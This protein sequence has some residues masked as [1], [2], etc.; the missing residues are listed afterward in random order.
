M[1]KS[2]DQMVNFI[3][4]DTILI[5]VVNIAYMLYKTLLHFVCMYMYI[6]IWVILL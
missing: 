5:E 2:S 1:S 6:Y 4:M 3:M